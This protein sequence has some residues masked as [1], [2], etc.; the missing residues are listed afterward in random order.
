MTRDLRILVAFLLS[1][2]HLSLSYTMQ[3]LFLWEFKNLVVSKILST[4]ASE[5]LVVNVD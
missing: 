1:L 2:L 5:I 4:S 3:P